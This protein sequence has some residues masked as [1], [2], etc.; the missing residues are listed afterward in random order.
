ML[1]FLFEYLELK[2]QLP[3]ASL[4]QY[5]SFRSALA[6]IF[7]LMLSVKYGKHIIN[8]LRKKQIGETIRDLGL[9][10]QKEKTG[11]PT[12][13][14]LIIIMATIIPV[15]LLSNFKNIF[16]IILIFTTLWLGFI[17]F[18]DDY[19][20]IFKKNKAGLKGKFKLIGQI[21]LGLIIGLTLFYHPDVTIKDQYGVDEIQKK[22]EYK[23]TK[24]TVPFLKDNELDYSYLI[25]WT[26][27]ES[28]KFSVIVFVFFV[29]LIVSAVSNGAN[30][31]DGVDGLAAGSS[32][33]IT[34]TLGI[35]A[36]VS[37]NIIFSEYLNVMY[38]P[39]ISEIVI[40]ISAFIGGLIGFLW[41]NTFPAQI[42]MGDTGSLTIGG[43]IAVIAIIVRKELLL[44]IICGIFLIETLSVI[45][46]VS[47]FKY[48]KNRSGVG[49]RIFLMS[50]IHH[51]FQKLGYHESKIAVRFW[52]IGILMAIL[53]L[54]TLK[55][56]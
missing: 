1:Y 26:G 38:I 17:G 4:F 9:S 47:Y 30:L 32:V 5:L 52:I 45:I 53:S 6:F 31:T 7:S 54:I 21:S 3:G 14:G 28:K 44:P 35:F 8:F 49:K 15:L 20:K 19:I 13:G 16:I 33:I 23:S 10:G 34:L 11:T 18:A 12:M 24:T 37:G 42:F 55:I 25:S 43:V 27:N 46:Q 41:Y 29:I 22:I 2:Y 36:W 50:P 56:R 48:S 40:F 39:R 51:H